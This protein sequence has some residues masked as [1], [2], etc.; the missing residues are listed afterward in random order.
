MRFQ[1]LRALPEPASSSSPLLGQGRYSP[2]ICDIITAMIPCT[3]TKAEGARRDFLSVHKFQTLIPYLRSR[4]AASLPT[5]LSTSQSP[6]KTFS[7][8]EPADELVT[9]SCEVGIAEACG[10]NEFLEVISW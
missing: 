8:T 7:Y 6:L 5:Q 9:R 10:D 4:F 3:K 1:W 2:H